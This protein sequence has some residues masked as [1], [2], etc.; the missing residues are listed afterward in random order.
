MTYE[1]RIETKTINKTSPSPSHSIHQLLPKKSAS[2]GISVHFIT[3]TD[4]FNTPQSPPTT[5]PMTI[6]SKLS[7]IYLC[8]ENAQ[9]SNAP[10]QPLNR[11]CYKRSHAAAMFSI[12][13]IWFP[14]AA[15]LASIRP[16]VS[17]SKLGFPM[18]ERRRSLL[19]KYH[20]VTEGENMT[21]L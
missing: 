4:V 3:Q 20:E 8:K 7:A 16:R 1:P 2:K 11:L 14:T 12:R 6:F 10:W 17:L 21:Y 13:F 19:R 18:V 15:D 5:K 9:N